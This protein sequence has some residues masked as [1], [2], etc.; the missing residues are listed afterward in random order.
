MT[1]PDEPSESASSEPSEASPTSDGSRRGWRLRDRLRAAAQQGPTVSEEQMERRMA[2]RFSQ[3]W[4]AVRAERREAEDGQ[5]AT[6]IHAGPSNFSRAHVPWGVDLAAAWSWRFLVIVAAGF[7]LARAVGFF[8]LVVL[9]LVIALFIAALVVPVVNALARLLPRGVAAILVELSVIGVVALM[10]T[11]ATRQVVSGA[12]KLSGQVVDALDQIRTWLQDGPLH[13]SD[14][15][16]DDAISGAQ[17][18][19]TSSTSEIVKR[20]TEV[21][22]TVG[23][24]VAALFIVL[25][26]TYFFM[27]DGNRIWTWVVRLFPRAA[28]ARA[29]AS[30]RVAWTSLTQFVR[31]TVIVALTDALGIM[32][33]AAVL[34]LPFVMAIGVLV[35]LG[36]FVPMVGAAIS[37]SV[38]VLVALVDQGPIVALVMLAGVIGVQQFEAHVLQPFLMGR[39]VSVHPLGV[40][41]AV[42]CGVL[43]AGIAGA[44]VAVPL[45]AALN[46]VVVYLASA[47]PPEEEAEDAA[48][49]VHPDPAEDLG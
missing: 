9:P 4:A 41:V 8:S 47:H 34:K 23:H 45:T 29:D 5:G 42:A 24:V 10:L 16:I 25:F 22:T 2:E 11:F 18:L 15:Q 32:A 46:A 19:V 36:A 13:A 39:M 3:H 38:A 44:L 14:K 33:V 28:R 37:G 30:G 26:A 7:V 6:A 31:A 20:A 17:N 27:A 12:D 48:A 49:G 35:F 40:I 1:A 43:V 21:G